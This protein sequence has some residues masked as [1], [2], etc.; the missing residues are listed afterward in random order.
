M[1]ILRKIIMITFFM[2]ALLITSNLVTAAAP[3]PLEPEGSLPVPANSRLTAPASS[4]TATISQIQGHWKGG[5]V[6]KDA[7]SGNLIGLKG[8]V[9]YN[10]GNTFS[11]R[12]EVK[13]SGTRNNTPFSIT[14]KLWTKGTWSLKNN[15][16]T[17][18]T[19]VIKSVPTIVTSGN[20]IINIA[21]LPA[22]RQSKV[23]ASLPNM[24]TIFPKDVPENSKVVNVSAN[25]LTLNSDG[26]VLVLTRV[27]NKSLN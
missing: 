20:T 15:V 7:Q 11:T 23:I 17:E 19:T 5:L 24:D 16:L 27:K 9:I 10:T 21:A 22:D 13:I 8:T 25:T 12:I 6:R 3:S 2:P 14:Y 4:S 1:T 26:D 18:T